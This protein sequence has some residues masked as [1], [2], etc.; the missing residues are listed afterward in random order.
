L[1]ARTQ[2]IDVEII[3]SP[4]DG[5]WSAWDVGLDVDASEFPVAIEGLRGEFSERGHTWVFTST[6]DD[7]F[8]VTLGSNA[9]YPSPDVLEALAGLAAL[10][11]P[12]VGPTA[13]IAL[14][15]TPSR[16]NL[17]IEISI[18]SPDFTTVPSNEVN[19]QLAGTAVEA[20]AF[21]LRDGF[22]PPAV[23]TRIG[24]RVYDLEEFFVLDNDACVGQP[25]CTWT[26]VT[27]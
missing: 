13:V 8:A 5:T 4:D 27:A 10:A 24:V 9:G 1:S 23:S 16:D 3:G 22:A 26:V 18:D 15:P 20:F 21:R 6:Q 7:G 17:S 25:G 19:A 11:D 14:A 12:T 2:R